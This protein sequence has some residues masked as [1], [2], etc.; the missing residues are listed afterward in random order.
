[1]IVGR[2]RK[3]LQHMAVCAVSMG[4]GCAHAFVEPLPVICILN[5]KPMGF[6]ER[7]LDS[8]FLMPHLPSGAGWYE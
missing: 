5:P 1:M 3:R 7:N 4:V 8:G 6:Q 2:G